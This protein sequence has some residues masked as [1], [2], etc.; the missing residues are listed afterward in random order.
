MLMHP[1]HRS[2]K[3]VHEKIDSCNK[4]LYDILCCATQ[5]PVMN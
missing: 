4:F 1:R 3:V 2:L 5:K